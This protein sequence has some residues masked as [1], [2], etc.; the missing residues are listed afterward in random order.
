MKRAFV[1]LACLFLLLFAQQSA[2]THAAW[3]ATHK[4]PPVQQDGNGKGSFQSGLCN[5]H[6][7]FSQVLGGVHTA[8]LGPPAPEDFVEQGERLEYSRCVEVRLPFLSRAPP[9]H[10]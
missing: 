7:A 5:L 1:H 2:L 6:V 9:V 10:L 8:P 4:L 3:H